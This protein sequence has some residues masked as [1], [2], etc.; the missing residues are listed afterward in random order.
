VAVPG[1]AVV[2]GAVLAVGAALRA[3]HVEVHGVAA[4]AEGVVDLQIEPRSLAQ[5]ASVLTTTPAV[6][7][8]HND[9]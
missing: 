5:V 8:L 6:T 1:A 9:K 7:S 2:D 4:E 3:V